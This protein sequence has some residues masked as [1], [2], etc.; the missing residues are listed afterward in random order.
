[1]K[2]EFEATFAKFFVIDKSNQKILPQDLPSTFLNIV[3]IQL[4]QAKFD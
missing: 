4:Q 2:E 1:M 3:D